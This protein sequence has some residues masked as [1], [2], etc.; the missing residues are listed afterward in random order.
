MAYVLIVDDDP[1]YSAAFCDSLEQ[2]AHRVDWA[3][4]GETARKA[5]SETAYD[6][7]FLDVLMP[8]GG[9]VT[10]LHTLA[11]AHPDVPLVVISGQSQLYD[12]PLFQE[13][14]RK[15]AAVLKKTAS[16]REIDAVI[17]RTVS[18]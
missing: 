4:D 11:A 14:L 10:L 18:K 6:I 9:A 17:N 15:A 1:D 7:V 2:L 16:L 8:G 5:L 12:S 3:V 13:G